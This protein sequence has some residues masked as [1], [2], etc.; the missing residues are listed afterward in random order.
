MTI[1]GIIAVII[2]YVMS[3]YNGINARRAQIKMVKKS[4]LKNIQNAFSLL[5]KQCS[6]VDIQ[7]AVDTLK[8]ITQINA[9]ND[10]LNDINNKIKSDIDFYNKLVNGLNSQIQTFPINLVAKLFNIIPEKII[11]NGDL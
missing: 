5:N 6:E 1:I 10:E 8:N 11:I 2:L 4:L 3:I 9:N 7:G